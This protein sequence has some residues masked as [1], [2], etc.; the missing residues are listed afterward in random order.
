MASTSCSA[1]SAVTIELARTSLIGEV[2]T[3]TFGWFSAGYQEL[4]IMMR[5]HPISKSGVSLILSSGSSMA[6]RM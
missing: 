2:S 6:P 3:S 4:V 5:L 1:P